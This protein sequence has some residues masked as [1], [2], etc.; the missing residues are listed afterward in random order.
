MRSTS[1]CLAAALV[2]VLALPA[3]AADA[4]PASVT[5]EPQQASS[6]TVRPTGTYE[7]LC[8]SS[9]RRLKTLR[10]SSSRTYSYD[11]LTVQEALVYLDFPPPVPI[12][13]D[14]WYGPVTASAVKAHQR[15]RRLYVDGVVG[16]QTW[17]QLRKEI[18]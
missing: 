7:Y 17:R 8:Y 15:S 10:P 9:L 6:V 2:A 1:I 12:K 4:A 3:G 18:C 11:A 5:A 14:G 13:M 16:P